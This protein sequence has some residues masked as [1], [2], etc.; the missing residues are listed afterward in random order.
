MW[1]YLTIEHDEPAVP[2]LALLGSAGWELAQVV[3]IEKPLAAVVY[4]TTFKRRRPVGV[5]G[6]IRAAIRRAA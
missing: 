6:W 3:S 1:E 4:Q 2:W 5:I